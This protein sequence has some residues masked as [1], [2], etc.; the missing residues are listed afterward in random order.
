MK[1][2]FYTFSFLL[3]TALGLLCPLPAEAAGDAFRPGQVIRYEGKTRISQKVG[4]EKPDDDSSFKCTLL[5]ISETSPEGVNTILAVRELVPEG[6]EGSPIAS[7]DILESGKDSGLKARETAIELET[8]HQMVGIYLPLRLEIP[9]VK[10]Q[11]EP[12]HEVLILNQ[13]PVR[14]RC[15]S[16]TS[17]VRGGDS[18]ISSFSNADKATFDFRGNKATLNK[19]EESYTSDKKTGVINKISINYEM[20]V[21]INDNLITLS[22]VCDLE[23][24]EIT[25]L[26]KT[27]VLAKGLAA[28]RKASAVFADMKPSSETRPLVAAAG[29]LLAEGLLGEV[30]ITKAWNVQ[31]RGFAKPVP[32]SSPPSSVDYDLWLGPAKKRPFNRNC[33]HRTW[34]LFREFGNGDFGDDGAHDLDMAAFGLGVKEHPVRITA[35]GSNVKPPGYREFPDNMN[36][37]FEF[38]DGRVLIYEDRLFTPYGMHGVDSGNAFY[39]TQGYMIFSRR[40]YFRTYLGKKEE[41]GPRS[42][43]AGRVGAP[44]PSHMQNFLNSI[45]SRKPTKA[46]ADIAHR[47]CGLIH[48]GEIAYRTRTVLEFDP[49]TETITNSKSAN[50]RLNKEYRAPFGLPQKV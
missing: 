45:R 37:S 17:E 12:N 23:A 4:A 21:F 9:R 48:L 24:K 7:F 39:G 25:T 10:L 28:F 30:R 27:P 42:G 32:N 26:E 20:S 16:S 31:D 41:P 14:I 15:A 5:S 3:C 6:G 46:D 47:T 43:K 11:S 2:G 40:G 44:I 29:K 19:W 22:L 50:A 35:H 33:F 1:T 49:K 13:I 34:R 18:Y 36:V 38:A 8:P